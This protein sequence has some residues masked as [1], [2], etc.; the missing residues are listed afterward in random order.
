MIAVFY[1][2]THYELTNS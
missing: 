2:M 1:G